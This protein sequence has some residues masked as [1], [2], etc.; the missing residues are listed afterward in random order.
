[1]NS[2]MTHPEQM[3]ELLECWVTRGWLREVDLALVRFFVTE[4]PDTCPALMLAAA[5]VSHQLGRGHV[6][7]D[8]ETTLNDPYMALS[9]PPEQE[10]APDRETIL[11][12]R[13]LLTDWAPSD[14]IRALN[15]PELVSAG[16]NNTPLVLLGHRL[17]LRRYWRYERQVESEI[18]QR[19]ARC[20]S[21]ANELSEAEFK[22]TLNDLF[23][24][25][26]VDNPDKTDWQ[27]IACAL[28]ARSAFSIITGGPG[29]GKTTTVV[30]LLALLQ[31]N[32]LAKDPARPLQIRL[33]APTGKAAARL[34]ASIAGAINKLP[35][36]VQR[37]EALKAGIPTEVAT[38]H[39]L[40]GTR[41]DSRMFRHD[42]R[43]PLP[44]DV[45]VVDEGSMVDLEMMAA[46]LLALPAHAH[47]VLLGDKDQLAS[48]EAGSVL[49]E[50]CRRAQE[51][52]F[53]PETT[54]WVEAMSGERI[55]SAL[56][57]ADGLPL[58]QH[59]VML[60]E[61]HRF[62]AS[63][64][65]GQLAAAV[66]AGKHEKIIA[67]WTRGY[68]DL[69][70]YDLANLEDERLESILLGTFSEAGAPQGLAG[71][72][73]IVSQNRPAL[74]ADKTTFDA[75]A[76]TILK[77]H[78]RFQLLCALRTGPFGVSGMNMYIESLLKK[79]HL[80]QP[81][82]PWYE[83]RPV[84]VTRNDYRLG[85]MNGDIGITLP[86]PARNKTSGEVEWSIR[87]AFPKGD[88]S[89]G[90]HW[91][92][93][94][95]LLSIE[96]VFA[97]TVHKSQGSE[98]EHCALLLPPERNPVLTREL[99]YTGVTRGKSWFSMIC[100]GNRKIV[101]ETSARTVQRSGGLFA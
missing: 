16:E 87:V 1:M 20:Q 23:P 48:V 57:D 8:L 70:R 95:R 62:D 74:D 33:A 21:V 93:P 24:P 50:L 72:L 85:L 34:K 22:A 18:R 41:P 47:L 58:D 59:I 10:G 17:Y 67:V 64:G 52:H 15:H 99:V 3:I 44:I 68:R 28:A 82:G 60:R 98:F 40:L 43:N 91:A 53:L 56:Q 79:H 63:S 36:F 31:S 46:L 26:N 61:S 92:L 84:L 78:G 29:T 77:A 100:V 35:D 97:L 14:W 45:L 69:F 9:L 96:T 13:D 83:G 81:S 49:G 25:S 88:G 37:N 5:L 55:E 80:I 19:I 54:R 38:L 94:S 75:W 66:N 12:P 6:C 7:L 65:I 76:A 11:Q 39:R 42:A 4:V 32:A 90:I 101:E 86:Y 73:R 51:G 27:K 30:R 71:Y 2:P 89:D